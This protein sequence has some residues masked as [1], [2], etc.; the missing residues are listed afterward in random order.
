MFY[1]ADGKDAPELAIG[2]PLRK[3][4]SRLWPVQI[5]DHSPLHLVQTPQQELSK[6]SALLDLAEDRLH[7]R[8]AQH[9]TLAAPFGLQLAPHPV[10]GRA[11][12]GDWS[13][14]RWRWLVAVSGLLG[15]DEGVCAQ[16][17]INRQRPLPS[18]NRR[19]RTPPWVLRPCWRWSP[20]S[21]PPPAACPMPGWW[22]GPPRSPDPCCPPPLGSCRPAGSPVHQ[23]PGMMR[24]STSV[25]LRWA[26]SSGTSGCSLPSASARSVQQQPEPRLPALPAPPGSSPTD[27]PEKPTPRATHHRVLSL[28]YRRSFSSSTAWA[29]RSNAST[30]PCNC[31]SCSFM[32]L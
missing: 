10:F 32:R 20:R 12:F 25:K 24:D 1:A 13:P 31:A 26:L 28:P 2:R 22:L 7:G 5:S 18:S 21:S 9:V 16:G 27:L 15:R 6:A 19:R 30:S 14:G 11:R 29:R 4:L 8:H 17:L 3:S 23:D